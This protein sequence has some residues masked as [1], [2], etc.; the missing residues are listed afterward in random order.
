M[1]LRRSCREAARLITARLDGPL[2]LADRL[3]LR[4]H[5]MACEACPRFDRQMRWLHTAM[6]RWRKAA[7]EG[8]PLGEE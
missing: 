4:L 8:A 1:I 7:D 2:P 6:G 5:L 3:A